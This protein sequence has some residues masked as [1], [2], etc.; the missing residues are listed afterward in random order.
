MY[1]R[2]VGR[3]IGGT[4]RVYIGITLSVFIYYSMFPSGRII[5]VLTGGLGAG[6][7]GGASDTT[8]FWRFWVFLECKSL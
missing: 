8:D 6:G 2:K 3:V 5:I 4:V 1:L 7:R